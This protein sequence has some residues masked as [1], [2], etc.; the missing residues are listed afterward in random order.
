MKKILVLF[1]VVTLFS[2]FT[3]EDINHRIRKKPVI[4]LNITGKSIEAN[5]EKL[6]TIKINEL[7]KITG[8]KLKLKE[9]IA[10]K[11][12]Q[13]KIKKDLKY[14]QKEKPSKGQTAFTLGLI[15]LVVFFIPYVNL[16]SLPLAVVALI[17]G[18]KAKKEN[19]KDSKA[20]T[21]VILS[22]ISMGLFALALVLVVAIL[23]SG[24]FWI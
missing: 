10:F 9:K 17:I 22:I 16:A 12:Y 7:E 3:K 15:S 1:S 18:S 6:A 8:R 23:A 24:T 5:L 11:I 4:S 2:S 13:Y 21:G 14:K 20:K 19:P